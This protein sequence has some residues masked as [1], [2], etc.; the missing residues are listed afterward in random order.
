MC[1]H[2][3]HLPT[4]L[5]N[6][7]KYICTPHIYMRLLRNKGRETC[8]FSWLNALHCRAIVLMRSTD[9][10]SKNNIFSIIMDSVNWKIY[11]IIKVMHNLSFTQQS[12]RFC[13]PGNSLD[14][15]GS[16]W[17]T[18]LTYPFRGLFGPLGR[19]LR[20]FTVLIYV[21]GRTQLHL[22]HTQI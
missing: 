10:A 6:R 21:A 5:I 1:S 8:F 3:T 15:V 20:Y 9:L 11:A 12:K 17:T 14:T 16:C 19:E 13:R 18:Y 2:W 4:T 22:Q 7:W